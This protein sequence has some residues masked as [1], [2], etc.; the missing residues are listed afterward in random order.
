LFS[1]HSFV[2]TGLM[3]CSQSA[4]MSSTDTFPAT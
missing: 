2:T 1:F 4:K 3:P